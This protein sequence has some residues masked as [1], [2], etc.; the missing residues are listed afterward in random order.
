MTISNMT[1]VSVGYSLNKGTEAIT[2]DR[3]RNACEIAAV[4]KRIGSDNIKIGFYSPKGK[5]KDIHKKTCDGE[6]M[7]EPPIYTFPNYYIQDNTDTKCENNEKEVSCKSK[8]KIC[9][10]HCNSTSCKDVCGTNIKIMKD[11]GINKIISDE[12]VGIIFHKVI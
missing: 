8:Y 10:S 9:L 4:N 7:I 5:C 12:D 11:E 2:P 6:S 1:A 3:D